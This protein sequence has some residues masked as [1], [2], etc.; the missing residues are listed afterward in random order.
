HAAGGAPAAEETGGAPAAEGD[1]RLPGTE[2][3]TAAPDG[4]VAGVAPARRGSA[5]PSPATPL[6]LVVREDLGWQL[7]AV[8]AGEAVAEPSAGPSAD[9]L[10]ALRSQGACF[11]GDL[12]AATE[13]LPAEVDEGLWDLVARGLVTADAFS[14]VRSLLSARYRWR[15][16]QRRLPPGRSRLGRR[17][18]PAGSGLG[19]GRW[20]LL[21]SVAP[22]ADDG[23]A[24]STAGVPDRIIP[25]W[26]ISTRIMPVGLAPAVE[27]LAETVA[28]QLLQRWGVVTWEL[29]S[30]E[31][32]HLPWRE[33]VRALRRL[34]ARGL[35]LGGRFVAGLSGEQYALEDAAAALGEVR[36]EPA[37]GT[38]VTVA[39]TDPLNV[40]GTVLPGPRVP[41]L[42]H[43]Q[44]TLRGGAVVPDCAAG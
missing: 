42:R 18:A 44:V 4:A 9:V 8:R 29:W 23:M 40:T 13:R 37:A 15:A 35:A 30:R 7:D 22:T 21:P 24:A 20:A 12:V 39:A 3:R 16:R 31:S 36:S 27:E 14:A 38:L 33:V 25:P 32:Y 17:R 11:R 41:A 5:T 34:E 6:A 1:R 2:G 43:R 19:E 28:W 10:A 26:M